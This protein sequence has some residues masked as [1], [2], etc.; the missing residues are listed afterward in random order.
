[1]KIGIIVARF[2]TPYLHDGH[3]ALL[4]YVKERNDKVIIFLGTTVTRLTKN[5]PLDY[6]TRKK[7]VL[8]RFPEMIVHEFLDQK[9]N[10]KWNEELDKLIAELHEGEDIVLYGSRDSFIQYYKGKYRTETF[11]G[12]SN[13]SATRLRNAC[14]SFIQDSRQFREGIIYASAN[15][16]PVSYQATDTAI[17]NFDTQQILLGR[18]SEES[19]FRFIGGFVDVAD[20]SLEMSAKREVTEEC[21]DIETDQYEYINSLRIDDWRYKNSEDKI[22]TAFFCCHF[23]F[24]HP[25]PKDDIAELKW[26]NLST[27]SEKD[28]EPEHHLLLKS[29]KEYLI[30]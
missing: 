2:Q 8:E 23:I 29:L 17:I 15:R 13:V 10:D 16:Y 30:K 28:M 11:K 3:I 4:K 12:I 18:K 26:F 21:G 6:E 9:H 1:M 20:E 7:M 25:E 19:K 27:L 22:M 24:G 5:N 14:N